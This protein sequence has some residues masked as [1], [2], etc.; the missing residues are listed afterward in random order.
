MEDSRKRHSSSFKATVAMAAIKGE[1]TLAEIAQKYQI[2]PSQIK[3][4]KAEVL[5]GLPGLFDGG[6]KKHNEKNDQDIAYLERKIGQLTVENDYLKKSWE[7]SQQIRG[8]K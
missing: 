2:H 5:K 6:K 3:S 4:W 1:Q 8:G 7:K